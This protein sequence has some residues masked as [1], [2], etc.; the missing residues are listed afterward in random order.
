MPTAEPP[1][2]RCRDVLAALSYLNEWLL[3]PPVYRLRHDAGPLILE[4]LTVHRC[5]LVV[6]TSRM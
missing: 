4:E 3:C 1:A 5:L 6:N 2:Q